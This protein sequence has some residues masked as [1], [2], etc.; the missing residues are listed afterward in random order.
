MSDG[1]TLNSFDKIIN[2]DGTPT[3]AFQTK[4]G[5]LLDRLAAAETVIAALADTYVAKDTGT[6]D[7]AAS[8]GTA[9]RATH[10]TYSAATISNPPTQA[11]VQAMANALQ[12][13]SQGF[14]GLSDDL[15]GNAA[16]K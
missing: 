9:N 7:W 2:A 16:I 6:S 4:W 14:K 13:V 11:Q 3:L 5:Q 15:L 8:T 10:A 1:L 12:Q